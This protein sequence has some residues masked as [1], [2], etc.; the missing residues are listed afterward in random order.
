MASHYY[1]TAGTT[2]TIFDATCV[3]GVKKA[4]FSECNTGANA[5]YNVELI[6]RYVIDESAWSGFCCGD[7]W[8][9]GAAVSIVS[10]RNVNNKSHVF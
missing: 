9:L 2:G 6:V 5:V 1:A 4:Q 7:I 8:V 10:L 3:G